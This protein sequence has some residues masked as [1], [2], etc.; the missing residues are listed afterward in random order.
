M[1]YDASKDTVKKLSTIEDY[2]KV[3]NL[4]RHRAL[5]VRHALRDIAAGSEPKAARLAADALQDDA[6]MAEV[7]PNTWKE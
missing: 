6:R 4:I 3:I 1:S 5:L 7:D 2:L